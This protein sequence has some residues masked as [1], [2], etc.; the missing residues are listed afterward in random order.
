[1]M[2]NLKRVLSFALVIVMLF[3]LVGCTATKK[4]EFDVSGYIRSVLRCSYAGD[5][6]SY[7]ELTGAGKETADDY[8]ATTVH[9]AAVRFFSAYSM[10]ASD[11]QMD[12]MEAVLEEAYRNSKFTVNEKVE[13]ATGYDVRVD[14]TVQTTLNNISSDIKAKREA[15]DALGQ[16]TD[17]GAQYIDEV[18]TLCKNT[19]E[20]QTA[21]G[22]TATL[23][24]DIIVDSEG[25]ISLDTNLFNS[26]D[27]AI[28]PY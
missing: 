18:I 19:V 20:N 24:F 28:L 9:N 13:K 27:V 4:T 10:N 3:S 26:I 15:A 14:Y 25:Y 8:H 1:M 5:T 21:Y 6:A 22:D 23:T 16:A 17:I 2:K 11:A 7:M 12:A